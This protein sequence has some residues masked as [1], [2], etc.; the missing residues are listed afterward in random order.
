MP[1]YKAT[2][3]KKKKPTGHR[4]ILRNI[5]K[6]DIN[7]GDLRY[8][9]PAGQARDLFSR[10]AHLALEDVIRSITTGS[11]SKRLG[12]T[13]IVG[14]NT[15][16]SPPPSY[17]VAD[18]SFVVFPQRI[19][20]SIVLGVGDITEEIQELIL[21]EDEEVLKKLEEDSMYS[22]EDTAPI[23]AKADEED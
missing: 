3:Y 22:G 12:K 19:K 8:K 7:L 10:T 15:L 4:Y 5:S 11:I 14:H 17:E 21:T 16:T 1:R 20:S 18:P 2:H 13:L 6:Y 9:I 23:V